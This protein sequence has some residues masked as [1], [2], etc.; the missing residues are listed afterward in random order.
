MIPLPVRGCLLLGHPAHAPA[1]AV[2]AQ[3]AGDAALE[4]LLLE[5]GQRRQ[6]LCSDVSDVALPAAAAAAAVA[7]AC[8]SRSEEN[9][10]PLK[11]PCSYEWT[12]MGTFALLR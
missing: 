4:E 8:E 7:V 9:R 12:A 1:A 10:Y 3:A 6:Q 5:L 11:V 2:A